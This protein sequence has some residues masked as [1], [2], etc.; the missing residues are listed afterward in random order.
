MGGDVGV[1]NHGD[2]VR[3]MILM[4]EYGMEAKDLSLIHI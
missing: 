2:N 4:K 1:F 3:E